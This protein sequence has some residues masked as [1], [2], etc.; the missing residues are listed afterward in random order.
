MTSEATHPLRKAAIRPS[1]STLRGML[2]QKEFKVV[3]SALQSLRSAGGV[4]LQWIWKGKDVGWVCSANYNGTVVCE[5]HAANCPIKGV[6]PLSVTLV[7]RM[8][9]AKSFPQGFKSFLKHPLEENGDTR[10][11]ELELES[12]ELRDLLSDLVGEIV[13]FIE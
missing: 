3:D 5:L 4:E 13:N 1:S 8:L 9:G 11:F 7:D 6:L 2:S 12:T 10:Y